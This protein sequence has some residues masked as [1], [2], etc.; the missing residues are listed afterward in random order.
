[1]NFVAIVLLCP[2]MFYKR[3]SRM[4]LCV[5]LIMSER[6]RIHDWKILCS[7]TDKINLTSLPAFNFHSFDY[8]AFLTH[9]LEYYYYNQLLVQTSLWC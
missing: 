4:S 6:G 1:M 7:F 5:V 3:L 8:S 9:T 2:V